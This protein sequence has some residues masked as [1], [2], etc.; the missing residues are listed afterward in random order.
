MPPLE[1]AGLTVFIVVLFLG[2]FSTVFGFPGT[3]II[4]IDALIYA[5]ITG[6]DKVGFKAIISLI[7][8]S[9][10]AEALDFGLSMA[11]AERFGATRKGAW[12]SVIGG[13]I[14]AVAMSP[15][16]YGLGAFAG[17]FIGGFSGIFIIEM[18]RQ[19]GFKPALR[20]SYGSILGRVAAIITKGIVSL[21]MVIV[22]LLSVYS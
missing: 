11:G 20:A 12:A 13:I 1:I 18:I 19:G 6:F 16:F 9:I 5:L 15:F 8:L 2:V 14:G 3:I 22:V 17:A 4:L 21:I 10:L 7:I